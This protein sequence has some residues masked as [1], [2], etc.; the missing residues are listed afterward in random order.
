MSTQITIYVNNNAEVLQDRISVSEVDNE[1]P[2]LH[3]LGDRSALWRGQRKLLITS[4]PIPN[5][6]YWKQVIGFYSLA[7]AWPNQPTASLS[8]D[9]LRET[10]LLNRIVNSCKEGD[11]IELIPYG[12]TR[13]FL[14]MADHLERILNA[15]GISLILPE[16]PSKTALWLSQ[17][18]DTKAGFRHL[19]AEWFGNELPCK[20][21][22]G[23]IMNDNNGIISAVQSFLLRGK[24]CICKPS[25]GTAGLGQ[26]RFPQDTK[27][28]RDTIEKALL[29]TPYMWHLPVIV[30]EL[31]PSALFPSGEAYVP[32]INSG[33]LQITYNCVQLFSNN[34]YFDGVL[35]DIA[36]LPFSIEEKMS[37]CLHKI[38]LKLQNLGYAGIFDLDFALDSRDSTLHLLEANLRRS[39]GT[40]VHETAMMLF[41]KDY[42]K[43]R[44][45]LSAHVDLPYPMN[46]NE[47][48]KKIDGI[49]FPMGSLQEGM[50]ITKTSSLPDRMEYMLF[51]R[52]IDYVMNLQNMFW[53][54]LQK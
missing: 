16:S 20:L 42:L 17:Y 44:T 38:G 14:D 28:T 5:L 12:T 39:G 4:V 22:E 32:K 43:H 33:E 48:I 31:I 26:I 19:I 21:P 23:Y 54:A 3:R 51:G 36:Q 18:F 24:G 45:V 9:I 29:S 25:A 35:I 10:T 6:D 52:N 27:P 30:E 47:L 7:N 1:L 40:H 37:E 34:N 53:G 46:W 2:F 49:M 15:S 50:I 41:G 13:K 8:Y 11:I